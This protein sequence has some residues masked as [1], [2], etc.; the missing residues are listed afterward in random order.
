MSPTVEHSIPQLW[1]NEPRVRHTPERRAPY[2]AF[3][4]ETPPVIARV[5]SKGSP[6]HLR[7]YI[8]VSDEISVK[9]SPSLLMVES[10][11]RNKHT[12]TIVITISAPEKMNATQ[13][14]P[15]VARSSEP[16]AVALSLKQTAREMRRRQAYLYFEPEGSGT[17]LGVISPGLHARLSPA[18]LFFWT[19]DVCR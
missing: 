9:R 4:L 19:I 16:S 13:K 17:F 1:L 7:Q 6:W 11:A 3:L 15:R 10:T 2:T 14:R 5:K 8:R 12:V 18:R